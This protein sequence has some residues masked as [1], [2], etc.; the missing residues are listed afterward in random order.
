MKMKRRNM[1]IAV[2]LL[3]TLTIPIKASPK[4]GGTV[5]YQAILYGITKQHSMTIQNHSNG[6]DIGTIVRILFFT[7]YNDVHFV[8]EKEM[9]E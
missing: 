9:N 2:L 4:D 8:S 3:L 6:Y 1:M 7:V 5:S